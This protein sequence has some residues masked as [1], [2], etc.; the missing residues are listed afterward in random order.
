M[1][2]FPALVIPVVCLTSM[3]ALRGAE[4]TGTSSKPNI[5]IILADDMGYGDVRCNNPAGLTPTPAIDHLAK[6]GVRF[7][8]AHSG[9][10]VCTPTRYGIMT[11]Q[12][13]W[14]TPAG[15]AVLMPYEKPIVA[16]D[17][18]TIAEM[19][20]RQGYATACIGKWHLGFKYPN[21]KNFGGDFTSNETHIDFTKPLDDGPMVHGFDFF[22][23]G[24]GC[25][26]SDPPYAFIRGDRTLGIPDRLSPDEWNVLPGFY[27]GLIAPG[28]TIET[29]DET[30]TR[31]AVSYIESRAAD[32]TGKPFF[33][34][35]ALSTPHVP[36]VAPAFIRGTSK[37][38]PRGDMNALADWAVGQVY[39]SLRK[40]G[41]LDRTLLIFSIDNGPDGRGQNGHDS[42]GGFRGA[43]NSPYEGGHR[44]P[45]VAR[46]PE[47]IAAGRVSDATISLTD[48][49]ATLAELTGFT[50]PDNAAED[51][52]SFLPALL[53]TG[54]CQP[55]PGMINDT[56]KGDLALRCGRWKYIS[57]VDL[58]TG[59]EA[60]RELF[61]LA[62]DPRETKDL[63]ELK[64]DL[65]E[66][67]ARHLN[68]LRQ[69]GARFIVPP[70][71]LYQE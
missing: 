50:L 41:L 51:S 68:R 52:F 67:L 24:A 62:D 58:T 6:E 57:H 53:G 14:R 43:K 49:M 19:L 33:L 8:D 59:K 34:Y 56:R 13:M 60:K 63:I 12:H 70:T 5:I 10:A 27:P 1:K 46:W 25:P 22:F 37:E 44:E 45:F 64:P 4:P 55:N 32:Q 21:K 31:Q 36:W 30:L 16:R 48:L 23:G 18:L 29:V 26:S 69:V 11:G 71:D 65:A 7:T 40:H 20:R 61:D 35:F 38:G 66:R 17:R 28:W 39:E 9:G 54:E 47:R 2:P 15:H 3:T 42:T